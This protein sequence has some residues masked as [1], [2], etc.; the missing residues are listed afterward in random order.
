[1]IVIEVQKS[2]QKDKDFWNISALIQRAID[3]FFGRVVDDTPVDTGY[4]ASRWINETADGDGEIS[5]DAPYIDV[6]E[7]GWSDQAPDGMVEINIP[8]LE[9]DIE[10]ILEGRK[11]LI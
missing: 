10:D 5:N 2:S 11:T 4:A 7:E 6:L 8:Q 3:K 1:M 9:D